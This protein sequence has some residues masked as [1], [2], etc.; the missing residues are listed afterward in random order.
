[1]AGG[2]WG[3]PEEIV[4]VTYGCAETQPKALTLYCLVGT[5]VHEL[6]KFRSLNKK[7]PSKNFL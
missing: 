5:K 7:E 2:P 4:V 3:T 6:P 1:M